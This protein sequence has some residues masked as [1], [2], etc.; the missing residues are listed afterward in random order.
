MRFL[1]AFAFALS[2]GGQVAA[3]DGKEGEAPFACS[4]SFIHVWGWIDIEEPGALTSIRKEDVDY[5]IRRTADDGEILGAT[6]FV[7]NRN[8]YDRNWKIFVRFADY[9]KFI[10]CLD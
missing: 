10:Q 6:I 4:E 2:V 9:T 1:I 8:H 3:Q 7:A 5:I